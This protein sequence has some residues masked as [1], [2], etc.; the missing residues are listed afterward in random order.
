MRVGESQIIQ[1]PPV[2]KKE[3]ISRLFKLYEQVNGK[4][5]NAEEQA[6]LILQYSFTVDFFTE[7]KV[8]FKGNEPV[9]FID[10]FS[11][12]ISIHTFFYN[13][14]CLAS[15]RL[16]QNSSEL[17]LYKFGNRNIVL[18][19]SLDCDQSRILMTIMRVFPTNEQ[20]DQAKTSEEEEKLTSKMLMLKFDPVKCNIYC[21]ERIRKEERCET[22]EGAEEI[23][24]TDTHTNYLYNY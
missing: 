7:F 6:S 16:K 24:E 21:V 4:K 10:T 11:N 1:V 13:I 23:T 5:I 3:S 14:F 20:I 9:L 18:E 2:E 17:M 22:P 19:K 15:E 12:G 8:K